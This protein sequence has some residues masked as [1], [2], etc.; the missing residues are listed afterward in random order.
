MITKIV[1]FKAT[2]GIILDGILQKCKKNTDKILIEVHGMT[3][4]CFKEREKIIADKVRKL[5]IDTL[6]FN[7]RGSEII[8][9]C[10][11]ENGEKVIATEIKKIPNEK[12]RKIVLEHLSELNDGKRDFRF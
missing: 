9:Y 4:N 1:K 5:G 11:K 6:C 2:D 7:N 8:K 3:S 12:V 10:T